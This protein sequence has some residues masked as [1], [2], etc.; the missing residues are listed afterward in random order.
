MI[1]ASTFD[2]RL[3][4]V[5]DEPEMARLPKPQPF[6]APVFIHDVV[7]PLAGETVL[8]LLMKRMMKDDQP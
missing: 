2:A 5:R 4:T 8:S 1:D 7:T 3:I 6:A